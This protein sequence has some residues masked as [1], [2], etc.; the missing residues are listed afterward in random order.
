MPERTIDTGFWNDPAVQPVSFNAKGLYLYSWTNEH[1]NQ[2]GLY[3]ITMLTM[4]RETGLEEPAITDALAELYPQ[5]IYFADKN[6]MWVKPFVKRQRRSPKFLVAAGRCLEQIPDKKLVADYLKY[7]KETYNLDI[8]Y[9]YPIDT[10]SI[11][12]A[13]EEDQK[14]SSSGSGS[15][16]SNNIT[17]TEKRGSGGEK[18]T[19]QD[20]KLAAIS[21]LYEQNIGILTPG[22]AD[23]LKWIRD[24]FPDGWFQA[25]LEEAL[26]NNKRS[27]AYITTILERWQV[28]GFKSRAK[29]APGKRSR[30]KKLSEGIEVEE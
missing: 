28:E 15:D 1:C 3:E 22:I 25:A 11:P 17:T 27:L 13:R 6:I 12:S 21:T 20:P 29:E 14:D 19:Q 30:G 26:Y 4:T 2:A 18:P 23:R 16:N 9:R 5:V 8:P 10:L 7:Y 24:T